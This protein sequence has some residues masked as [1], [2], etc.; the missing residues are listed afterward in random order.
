M[1]PAFSAEAPKQTSAVRFQVKASEGSLMGVLGVR[2]PR[3]LVKILALPRGLDVA[4]AD[5]EV[6]KVFSSRAFACIA[7][8]DRV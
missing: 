6:T 4:G 1:V 7:M 8:K 2:Q 5:D 3:L